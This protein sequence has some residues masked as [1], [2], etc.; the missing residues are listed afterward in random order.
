MQRTSSRLVFVCYADVRHREYSRT[1][2]YGPDDS[3]FAVGHGEYVEEMYTKDPSLLWASAHPDEGVCDTTQIMPD[4]DFRR[5]PYVTWQRSRFGTEHWRVFFTK[6]T[7]DLSFA[8][9]LHPP[10]GDGPASRE[11]GKLHK[12]LFEHMERALR[13]AARPPDLAD[14]TSAIVI[15]DTSGGV[16][17][18]SPR[19]EQLLCMGDG[20]RLERRRLVARSPV[21]TASLECAILSAVKSAS[22][23][24]TGG[25][26][27]LTRASGPDWL[28]LVSPCPH[29]LEHL[30]V[31]TPAAVL[32]IVEA[33]PG[34]AFT[35]GQAALFDLTPREIEVA[36]ELL[37]GHSLESIC[38]L[39]AI[40]RNTVKAHLQSIFR[41]TATNRQ[42][43]LVHLLCDLTRT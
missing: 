10:A 1:E 9:S 25:G 13:L 35:P 4:R 34:T 24:G 42:S 40:S 43:E 23:G 16:L 32:R 37:S 14:E 8:L 5:L 21:T 30:P 26:V 31:R 7:D 11:Q 19:A 15:L 38:A 29:F 17:S 20:L 28:A 22:F 12:L 2:F 39:L 3:A 6:P 36:Q 27:R 18:M 33:G 41:K